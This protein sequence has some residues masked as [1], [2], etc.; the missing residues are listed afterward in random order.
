MAFNFQRIF[1]RKRRV[2]SDNLFWRAHGIDDVIEHVR[3]SSTKLNCFRWNAFVFYQFMQILRCH[4]IRRSFCS[5]FRN[6]LRRVLWDF[7]KLLE[8]FLGW[9]DERSTSLLFPHFSQQFTSPP[10]KNP[11]MIRNSR[12]MTAARLAGGN[13]RSIHF[14]SIFPKQ[15]YQRF[16]K[17]GY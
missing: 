12:V 5:Q 13:S 3:W 8:G 6:V 9:P 11:I 2:S 7:P 15:L 14:S 16:H 1:L 17:K 10:K 4:V